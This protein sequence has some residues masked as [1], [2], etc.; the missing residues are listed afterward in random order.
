M[1]EGY[2]ANQ[3]NYSYLSLKAK[4]NYSDQG[5]NTSAT[6]NFRMKRDSILWGS[7]GLLGFEGARILITTDSFK[8]MNR[9]NNTYMA[10]SVDYLNQ[11]IGFDVQLKELQDI[12][13]GNAPYKSNLYRLITTDS[14]NLLQAQNGSILNTIGINTKLQSILS[15]FS[16]TEHI[17]TAD[18]SYEEYKEFKTI[19]L[20][21][22]I[23][24]NLFLGDRNASLNLEYQSANEDPIESFPFS[25]PS[26]FK[27]I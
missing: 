25:V 1:V 27:K 12:M 22:K 13:V 19:N 9:L 21:F 23:L 2:W 17:Q 26:N 3:L 24:A 5:T 7:F 8:M 18:F 4:I 14:V 11:I 20:P 16:S 15:T 10:R 6:G